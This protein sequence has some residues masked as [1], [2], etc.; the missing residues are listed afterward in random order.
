MERT[1]GIFR[2]PVVW[3]ILVIIGAITLSSFFTGG[4]D[5]TKADTSVAVAQLSDNNVKKALQ[6]DRE[7]NLKLDLKNKIKV[8]DTETDKIFAQYPAESA[9]VIYNQ[10]VTAQKSHQI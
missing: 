2:R 3:I 5:Y 4:H 6:E 8:G 1:R 10:L 7:Q 9:A